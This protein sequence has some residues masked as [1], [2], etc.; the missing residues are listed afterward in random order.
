M[1]KKLIVTHQLPRGPFSALKDDFEIL[2]L[3]P[4]H[5]AMKS[6]WRI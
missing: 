3:M 6:Y 5:L 1:K 4:M 2:C